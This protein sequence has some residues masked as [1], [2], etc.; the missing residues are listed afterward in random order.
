MIVYRIAKWKYLEDLSG[1]GARL[2]GGRWNKEGYAMLYTSTHLSLAVLELL[3]N[4]VRELI[5]GSY[6][7][8]KINIPDTLQTLRYNTDL[9]PQEW[10]DGM[11]ADETVQSG[12]D[13]LMQKSSLTL[14]VPSAVLTQESNVLINPKHDGFS[15]LSILE[16]GELA[17]DQRI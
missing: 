9:L 4:H 1:T 13:W 10:R 5:D 11:Y 12:T 3:A 14:Y 17:L 16:K 15:K 2:Y 7:Y 6:G 8:I